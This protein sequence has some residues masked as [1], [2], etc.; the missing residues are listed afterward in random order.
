MKKFTLTAII[1]LAKAEDKMIAA[2]MPKT[3]LASGLKLK[4]A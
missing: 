1:K 4:A 3:A 2:M